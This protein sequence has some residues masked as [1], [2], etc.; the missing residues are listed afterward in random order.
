MGNIGMDNNTDTRSRGCIS[1]TCRGY[2]HTCT[3]S[4]LPSKDND[5]R[6]GNT[7]VAIRNCG[8]NTLARRP[9]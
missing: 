8:G 3:D 9:E 4:T 5:M 1:H 6:A 7:V 2:T